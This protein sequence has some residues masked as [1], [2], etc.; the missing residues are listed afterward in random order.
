MKKQKRLPE[1]IYATIRS[2]GGQTFVDADTEFVA[3]NEG[4][5]VGV[6]RLEST[7]IKRITHEL[8]KQQ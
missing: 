7:A 1:I 5:I 6:Y 8:E 4:D 3:F 2:D